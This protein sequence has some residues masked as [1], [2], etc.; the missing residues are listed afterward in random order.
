MSGVGGFR[1]VSA[2]QDV[3][4]INKEKK[5]MAAMKFP[6][7]LDKK[8]NIKYLR[9]KP[10]WAVIK[11]W[12]AKRITQL[13]G[14]EEEVLIGM[15]FN[16]L[17]DNEPID[18]KKMHVDLLP[19]LEKNTSL[20]MKELWNMVASAQE[21]PSD[22]GLPRV[23]LEEK[24]AEMEARRRA[25]QELKAPVKAEV[26][27]E[28]D[29]R[30]SGRDKEERSRDKDAHRDSR[31]SRREG[32]DEGKRSRRSRSRS[33]SP[34]LRD[35]MRQQARRHRSP[36]RSVSRERTKRRARTPSASPSG[37][38]RSEERPRHVDEKVL[39]SSSKMEARESTLSSDPFKTHALPIHDRARQA[40]QEEQTQQKREAQQEGEAQQAGHSGSDD[41]DEEL[42]AMRLKAQESAKSAQRASSGAQHEA[43]H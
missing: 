19:F 17:E 29:M 39:R 18:P 35:R 27:A 24:K 11:E 37:S 34:G 30:S 15:V 32:R 43:K 2:E 33:R 1:G 12:I 23:L 25:E 42:R 40:E 8:V 38:D 22:S 41:E 20:F 6:K 13:L 36:S 26:K 21:D 7:E 4:Y 16:L 9:T 5:A 3:R 31:G 10:G 14:L 28:E